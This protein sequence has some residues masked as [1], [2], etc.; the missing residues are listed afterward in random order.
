MTDFYINELEVR[1]K[2]VQTSTVGFEEGVNFIIGPSDTGK[3]YITKCI[4]YALG[5]G[6]VP[7]QEEVTGYN[8]IKLSICNSKGQSL[9]ITRKLKDRDGL[10]VSDSQ[11]MVESDFDG[12]EDGIYST[13]KAAKNRLNDLLLG[14]IGIDEPVMVIKNEER[15]P[16]NLTLKSIAHLFNIDI[17]TRAKEASILFNPKGGYASITSSLTS[18]MYLIDERGSTTEPAD[19]KQ[20]KNAKKN[21]VVEYISRKIALRLNKN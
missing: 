11:V 18:L 1:G 12:I 7:F 14:L 21:A 2:T 15:S 4:A 17:D 6:D 9:N 3:T 5:Y 19:N 8:T 16:Q 10:S 20:I 13:G